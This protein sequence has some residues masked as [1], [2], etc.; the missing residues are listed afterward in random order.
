MANITPLYEVRQSNVL[1]ESRFDFTAVQLDIY[2][3]LLSAIRINDETLKEYEIHVTH[4]K[5]LTGRE[6]NYNQLRQSTKELIG[7]VIEFTDR[8][9]NFCQTGLL[10]SAKYMKG[11]GYIKV[12]ISPVI[13]PLLVELK[14][15]YTS[16]ELYCAL[17]M[18]SKFAKRLYLLCSEW[19]NNQILKDGSAVSKKYTVDELRHMLELSD[20]KGIKPDQFKQWTEFK[21]NVLEV[22]K[23]QINKYSDLKMSYSAIKVGRSYEKVQFN[24]QKGNEHQ[25]LID[26]KQ[27]DLQAHI[28]DINRQVL[29]MDTYGLSEKQAQT[30]VRRLDKKMVKDVLAEVDKAK[31]EGKIKASI[32]GYTV[33]ALVNKFGVQL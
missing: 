3:Y 17:A 5:E 19:K 27:E 13:F 16:F 12:S 21:V 20:P 11:K 22:A 32:G 28:L 7:R 14:E 9:G 29:L 26:F 1:T 25:L 24:I 30:V 10:A 8:E 18:T 6:W 15:Q 23:N 4:M 2:F 31:K 33:T